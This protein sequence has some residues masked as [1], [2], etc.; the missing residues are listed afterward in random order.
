MIEVTAPKDRRV[1]LRSTVGISISLK[2]GETRRVAPMFNVCAAEQ[3][4][5]VKPVDNMPAPTQTSN[6]DRAGEIAKAIEEIQASGSTDEVTGAG[7]PRTAAIRN[8]TG[9][10]VTAAEIQAVM[11]RGNDS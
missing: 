3:G 10:D 9:L 11:Q 6:D 7:N 8:R 2:P 5:L 1:R 4:C